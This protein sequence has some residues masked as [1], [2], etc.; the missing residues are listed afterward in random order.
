[1]PIVRTLPPR[2]FG[3]IIAILGAIVIATATSA[4]AVTPEELASLH[5]AGLGDEVLDAL[6]EATGVQ[7]RVDGTEA[8]ALRQ[9]GL[10][11]RIIAQ[12]IRRSAAGVRI[13]VEPPDDTAAAAPPATVA[14]PASNVA[15]MGYGDAEP[16]PAAVVPEVV[17]VPVLVGIPVLPH[18]CR[19]CN[20]ATP[21]SH[22]GVGRFINTDL[23]PLNTDLRPLNDGA[24]GAARTGDAA[25][26]TPP[27]R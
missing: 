6:I 14:I 2:P 5:Q 11:D 3:P 1:M 20:A 24:G 12:A 9:A 27:R 18:R 21:G 26:P 10:S 17:V 7:G 4:H 19:S 25:H 15:V 23:R 8:L 22:H 13:P 16:V